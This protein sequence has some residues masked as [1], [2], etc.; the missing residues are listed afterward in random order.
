MRLIDADRFEAFCYDV[1]MDVEAD[2]FMR[3][4]E[5]VLDKIDA[6][7]TIQPDWNEMIIICDCCGHAIHVKR[8]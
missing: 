2:S 3:G 6:A 4:V 7:P 5:F 8:Q 1:P